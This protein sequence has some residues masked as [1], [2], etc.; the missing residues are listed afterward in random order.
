MS[1]SPHASPVFVTRASRR[2]SDGP[3]GL[4]SDTGVADVQPVTASEAVSAVGGWR[5]MRTGFVGLATLALAGCSLFG[6]GAKP[7]GEPAPLPKI[8]HQTLHLK[9]AWSTDAGAGAGD[10]VTGFQL[11]VDGRRVY[12]ANRDGTVTA[13]DLEDGHVVWRTHTKLRVIS[14]PAVAEGT[15]LVGTRDGQVVALAAEDGSERWRADVSSEVLSAPAV[16]EGSVVVR[17]LDGRLVAF[18][19]ADGD[20]RWTVERSVPTLTLRGTASPVIV[21]DVVLAGMDNGKVVS[22]KLDNGELQWEQ[23]VAAPTGRSEL[24]RVVDLDASLLVVDSQ[25]YAVSVGKQL[26]SMSLS[27][28]RVRWKREIASRT[29]MSFDRDQVFVTDTSGTVWSVDRSSGASL[30]K[31]DALAYRRLSQPAMYR[32]YVVVGDF[33]GY[34]HWLIPEDGTIVARAHPVGSAIRAAPLVIGDRVLVL[35]A[36]GEVVALQEASDE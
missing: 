20:R 15:L 6:G 27:S 22:L 4:E 25:I 5:S 32:G 8:E 9:E 16:G 11:A 18:D 33:K 28:G 31:Q 26:A 1:I 14:G 23:R 19:L 29:G 7:G 10:Y 17:T 3:H 12:A 21:G 24:E 30:W 35:S 36:D 34:L 13:M 2:A